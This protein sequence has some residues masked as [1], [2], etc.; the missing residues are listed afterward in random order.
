MSFSKWR[1]RTACVV[2]KRRAASAWQRRTL[3]APRLPRELPTARM[4]TA[5]ITT[6]TTT[7]WHPRNVGSD[8]PSLLLQPLEVLL[9]LLLLLLRPPLLPPR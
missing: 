4:K 3:P 5:A 2:S 1:T 7:S 6:T 9:L 8:G